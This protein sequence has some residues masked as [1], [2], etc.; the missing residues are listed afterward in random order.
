[1]AGRIGRFRGESGRGYTRSVVGSKQPC[2]KVV[3][4]LIEAL[5]N[6]ERAGF[7]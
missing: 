5:I 4:S 7:A 6:S 3:A 1:M 2:K